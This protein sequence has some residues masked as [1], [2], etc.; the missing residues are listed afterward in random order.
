MS[1][2]PLLTSE[3]SPVGESRRDLLVTAVRTVNCNGLLTLRYI[4][5]Y[6]QPLISVDVFTTWWCYF[7]SKWRLNESFD[8]AVS[9]LVIVFAI[10]IFNC[11]PSV[12]VECR[13]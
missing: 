11:W 3:I 4:I 6:M 13:Y 1:I 12:S 8:L 7:Q 5:L 9:Q 2:N 10:S